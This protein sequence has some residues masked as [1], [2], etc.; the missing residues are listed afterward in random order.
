MACWATKTSSCLSVLHQI[1]ASV[2]HMQQKTWLRIMFFYLPDEY[3]DHLDQRL[4]Q[5]L[6]WHGSQDLF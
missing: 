2:W 4:S 1:I 6:N 5:I 3:L